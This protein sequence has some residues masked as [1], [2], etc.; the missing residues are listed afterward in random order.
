MT[1][2]A[3]TTDSGEPPTARKRPGGRTARIGSAVLAATLEIL[4]EDGF[5][6]LT[7]DEVA[8][9]AD[10]HKS[11]VYR[12]WGSRER[13]VG[14]ALAARSADEIP[15]PDTGTLRGDLEAIVGGVAAS[16]ATPLGRALAQTMVG[17]G[18]DPEIARITEE[19]WTTRFERTSVVVDRAIE[20]GELPDGA[21]TRLVVEMVVATIWFRSIVT[22][23][24]VDD[25]LVSPV[26]DA[27][28]RGF[29]AVVDGS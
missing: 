6:S 18:D 21:D 3:T 22:R 9:R 26:I 14:E 11:T 1:D 2:R 12:R 8:A 16:L 4:G 25:G 5:G 10:V 29:G 27:V 7:I 23:A 28:L 15:V 17:Q 20:R 19:F 24:Q 13:L